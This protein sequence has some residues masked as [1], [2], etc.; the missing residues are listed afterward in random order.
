MEKPKSKAQEKRERIEAQTERL[1]TLKS[2]INEILC[3][4]INRHIVEVGGAS[5]AAAYKVA[6]EKLHGVLTLKR[7]IPS[8]I[9][10]IEDTI[11]YYERSIDQNWS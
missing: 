2:K 9:E 1:Q 8:V 7:P 6:L 3:G 10:K 4:G 11:E 5:Q